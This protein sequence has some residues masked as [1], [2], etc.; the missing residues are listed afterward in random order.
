M[1]TE[2]PKSLSAK[3]FVNVTWSEDQQIS[4]DDYYDDVLFSNMEAY[5]AHQTAELQAEYDALIEKQ[6]HI[7]AEAQSSANSDQE[8]YFELKKD[9]T[10]LQDENAALRQLFTVAPLNVLRELPHG[11]GGDF[12]GKEWVIDPLGCN[13]CLGYVKWSQAAEDA[14]TEFSKYPNPL[15][16]ELA[17]L[18][19]LPIVIRD[20][21]YVATV[22]E[23]GTPILFS[24]ATAKDAERVYDKMIE[25][26][27]DHVY[28]DR[29][30]KA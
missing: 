12:E 6:N 15:Q 11:C 25:A 10:N 24:N 14:F 22:N 16:E 29:K 13:A 9:V 5:A 20:A 28:P 19:Q 4:W 3:E 17:R 1:S 8:R 30:N 27:L 23:D 2:Q 21:R 26:A 7:I 18:R